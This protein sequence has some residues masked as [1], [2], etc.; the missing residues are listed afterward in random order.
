MVSEAVA[1]VKELTPSV[2]AAAAAPGSPS[3]PGTLTTTG[4]GHP[5]L[6]KT[7]I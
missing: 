1:T 4:V 5:Q 7:V 3:V 2:P 6:F